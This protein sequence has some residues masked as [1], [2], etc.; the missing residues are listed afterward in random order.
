MSTIGVAGARVTNPA[1]ILFDWAIH[2]GRCMN[3]AIVRRVGTVAMTSTDA[4]TLHLTMQQ[5]IPEM[6][7]PCT[8]VRTGVRPRDE[9]GLVQQFKYSC[10][11][12]CSFFSTGGL[13]PTYA[14]QHGAT[15]RATLLCTLRVILHD[16]YI[17]LVPQLRSLA[18]TTIPQ[19]YDLVLLG[20]CAS[21]LQPHVF[22]FR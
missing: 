14:T 19:R 6:C 10:R 9:E 13:T 20:R 8:Q 2:K 15:T 17:I 12:G 7:A 18:S 22:S 3:E 21:T 1:L 5:L 4:Y 16:A 11:R